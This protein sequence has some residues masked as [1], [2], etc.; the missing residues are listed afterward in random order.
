MYRVKA[1]TSKPLFA[2]I[3][4]ASLAQVAN[5]GPRIDEAHYLI[6][7]FDDGLS[8]F[9]TSGVGIDTPIST[10]GT[11][12]TLDANGRLYISHSRANVVSRY[13]ARTGNFLNVFASAGLDMPAGL[14]F[15]PNGNLYVAS[16]NNNQIV[17]FD[18]MSGQ[19]VR[20][21]AVSLPIDLEFGPDNNL[22]VA[23]GHHSSSRS[24]IDKFDGVSGQF[25][26]RFATNAIYTPTALEFGPN[27]DL[28]V[29]NQTSPTN[30]DVVRLSGTTGA[31]LQTVVSDAFNNPQ[32]IR[33]DS[34]GT[35]L[36]ATSQLGSIRR[37]NP[38]TGQFLGN[39]ISR[40]SATA[41]IIFLPAIPEPPTARLSFITLSALLLRVQGMSGRKRRQ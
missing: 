5:A 10:D 40:F 13:D 36:L 15:G 37:Y 6:L 41:D 7:S 28:F 22:Y 39:L 2:L 3:T 16:P 29:S 9:T 35:M 23:A 17:E 4:F 11:R 18:G 1:F 26:Q 8:R 30:Q 34:D 27:G 20:S 38:T 12:M 33:F 32:S 19:Y 31:L 21:I 24:R 14:D 25:L